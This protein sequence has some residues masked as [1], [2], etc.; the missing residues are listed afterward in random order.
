MPTLKSCVPNCTQARLQ[1]DAQYYHL[2]I[3]TI[4]EI[5]SNANE[6][7]IQIPPRNLNDVVFPYSML[8]C[9]QDVMSNVIPYR[10]N[11]TKSGATTA[12]FIVILHRILG[13][14]CANLDAIAQSLQA[15]A[16]RLQALCFEIGR[17]SKQ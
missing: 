2:N 13:T 15:I 11:Y 1:I 16:S 4:T 9:A 7:G 12:N 3:G 14:Y 10:R 8:I 17:K 5:V 6:F